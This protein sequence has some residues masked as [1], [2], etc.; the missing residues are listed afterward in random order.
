MQLDGWLA[1]TSSVLAVTG[2][3]SAA[4]VVRGFRNWA[5]FE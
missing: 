1:I 4:S 2:I 5:G 3:G